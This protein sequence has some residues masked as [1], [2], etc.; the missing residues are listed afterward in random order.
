MNALMVNAVAV[1]I[2]ARW[3]ESRCR[4]LEGDEQVAFYQQALRLLVKALWATGTVRLSSQSC[5]QRS[6]QCMPATPQV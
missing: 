4:M 2:L 1:V 6:T 3:P 5:V